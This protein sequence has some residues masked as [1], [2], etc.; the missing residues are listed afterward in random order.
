MKPKP[1][2]YRD[3]KGRYWRIAIDDFAV[4][5]AAEVGVDL[6]T[7]TPVELGKMIEALAGRDFELLRLLEAVALSAIPQIHT[8]T[9]ESLIRGVFAFARAMDDRFPGQRFYWCAKT[10]LP[11]WLPDKLATIDSKA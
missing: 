5:R 3:G 4:R 2:F 1:H 7:F 11:K 9:V 10:G 8:I 6:P